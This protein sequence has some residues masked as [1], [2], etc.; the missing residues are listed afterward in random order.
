[1]AEISPEAA[2]RLYVAF[3]YDSIQDIEARRLIGSIRGT[4]IG[5]KVGTQ[6]ACR[7]GWIV[8]VVQLSNGFNVFAD[9]K[10]HDIGKTETAT[11]RSV[12]RWLPSYLNAHATSSFAALESLVKLRDETQKT[13]AE[14]MKTKLLGVTLPTDVEDEESM[15]D[16]GRSRNEQVLHLADKSMDAGF[17]GIVCSAY[18]LKLLA[19]YARFDQLV[20]VVPS[21]RPKWS[22]PAGQKNFVTPTEAIELGGDNVT[23]VVGSPI[24][25]QYMNIGETRLDAVVAVTNEIDAALAA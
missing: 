19:K 9:M 24:T 22:V 11:A 2:K 16:Y 18:D 23:L 14:N 1:M 20:K 6:L 25:D 4:G 17:E 10:L 3:D 15:R 12:L 21:I 5:A 8:P 7:S 13:A